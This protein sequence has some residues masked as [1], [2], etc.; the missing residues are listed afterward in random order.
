[1]RHRRSSRKTYLDYQAVGKIPAVFFIFFD[2]KKTGF[3]G[4]KT[5]F[6][7]GVLLPKIKLTFALKALYFP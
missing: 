4:E 2:D 3:M 5:N 6:F 7:E 1:M